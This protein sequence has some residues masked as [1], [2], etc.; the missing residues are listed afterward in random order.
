MVRP[1]FMQ[2]AL[3]PASGAT[4]AEVIAAEFFAQLDIAMDDAWSALDMGLR[5][6]GIA[7]LTRDAESWAGFRGSDIAA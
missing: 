6:E 1:D 7:S 4:G 5:G 2:Q 3:K